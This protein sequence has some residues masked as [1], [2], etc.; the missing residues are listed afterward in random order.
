MHGRVSEER[1]RDP[2]WWRS[3]VVYQVYPRSFADADGDGVGDIA[4]ITD[5][6]P[7]LAELGVDA[8]WVSPWYP[9]P[10]KDAGYDVADFRD[11]EPVFGTL[12]EAETFIAA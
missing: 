5:R 9:S 4:G 8:V 12:A 7:Y 6:L 10:M 2:L 3:A 1:Y 11:I